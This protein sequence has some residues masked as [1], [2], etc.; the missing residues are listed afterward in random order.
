MRTLVIALAGVGSGS[1][2]TLPESVTCVSTCVVSFETGTT[3]T[4]LATAAPGSIFADWET[5]CAGGVVTLDVDSGCTAVFSVDSDGDMLPDDWETQF[6]L[7]PGSAVGDDGKTGDPDGDG[8]TNAEELAAGTHPTGVPALTRFFAEGATG[9]NLGFDSRFA[10]ANPGATSA[11]VLYR[12]LR[13]DG[14]S[15]SRFFSLGSMTGT[16]CGPATFPA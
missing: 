9:G 10:T 5:G 8:S 15:V 1:V 4:L 16:P 11:R 6:G 7:N 12:F 3:V 2:T 13:A 14:N